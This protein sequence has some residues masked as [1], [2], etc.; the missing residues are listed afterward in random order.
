V[1]DWS[2]HMQSFK[3]ISIK[4]KPLWTSKNQVSIYIFFTVYKKK[5]LVLFEKKKIKLWNKWHFVEGNTKIMQHIL[6][7]QYIFL[8]REY[9]QW[10]SR[11][12]LGCLH[13]FKCRPFKEQ[14]EKMHTNLP[15]LLTAAQ[16]HDS[17]YLS[18]FMCRYRHLKWNTN[19]LV[20][21]PLF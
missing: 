18:H 9:M 20:L 19:M 8:L 14:A 1:V 16:R 15:L 3:Y 7:M 4:I 5:K 10:I 13:I 12:F 17:S 6:K 11:V 21:L 2:F